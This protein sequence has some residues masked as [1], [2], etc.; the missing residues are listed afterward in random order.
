MNTLAIWLLVAIMILL[1]V[2]EFVAPF[3]LGV[4][5]LVLAVKRYQKLINGGF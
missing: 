2:G 3:I 5:Y 1:L 4:A